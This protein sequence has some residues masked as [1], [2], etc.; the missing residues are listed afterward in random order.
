MILTCRLCD[1]EFVIHRHCYRGHVYCSETC[2]GRGRVETARAARRSYRRSPEGRE[3]HRDAQ[4]V[5]RKKRRVGDHSS[6]ILTKLTEIDS[7]REERDVSEGESRS[8]P[9]PPTVQVR[10]RVH[11][12]ASLRLGAYNAAEATTPASHGDDHLL[13]RLAS[14]AC[15]AC[16]GRHGRL[17]RAV[18]GRARRRP[19]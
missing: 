13:E 8:V 12:M 15:I 14:R 11:P 2:Q 19:P 17:V 4:R 6:K 9:H 1:E 3:D 18:G 16:G 7:P 5:R 10:R